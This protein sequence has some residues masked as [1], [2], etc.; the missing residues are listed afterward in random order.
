M[1]EG[2]GANGAVKICGILALQPLFPPLCLSLMLH[3]LKNFVNRLVG[4]SSAEGRSK[5]RRRNRRGRLIGQNISNKKMLE[6]HGGPSSGG[7]ANEN[8]R[9]KSREVKDVA[10][11]MVK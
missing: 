9:K 7:R 1:I 10:R 3:R 4:S 2:I 8:G 5:K 6:T 11:E